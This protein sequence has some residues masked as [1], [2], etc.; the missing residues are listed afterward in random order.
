MNGILHGYQVRYKGSSRSTYLPVVDVGNSLLKVFDQLAAFTEYDFQV[1][2][3]HCLNHI[4]YF[5]YH[6]S[7]L[8]TTKQSLKDQHVESY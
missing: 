6:N 7:N 8:D 1:R 3:Y 4:V 5:P 2:I